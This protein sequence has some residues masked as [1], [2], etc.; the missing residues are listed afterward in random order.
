MKSRIL[1]LTLVASIS[2]ASIAFAAD[3]PLSD[4]KALFAAASFD[5]AL[6]ALDRLDSANAARP[7][8]L[9]YKVLCL[10]ALGRS[11]DAQKITETLVTTVP[12]FA[13]ADTDLS[14]K[15]LELLTETRRRIVPTIA[16]RLFADARDQY[17]SKNNA[18]ATRVFQQVMTLA[19]DRVWRDTAEAEDL[20]T[21]AS[22]FLELLDGAA[23]PAPKAAAE[24]PPPAAPPVVPPSPASIA[25]ALGQ[26]EAPVPIRQTMPRWVAPDRVSAMR[27]FHGTIKVRIGVD[28]RVVDA[29]I[30]TP[31]HPDYDKLLLD[32][33]RTW[34]YKPALRNGQPIEVE[35]VVDFNLQT[36]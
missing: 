2:S 6:A 28:G 1:L 27:T 4:A 36:K 29:M 5:G 26:L 3:E 24:P 11:A 31:T 35:K 12:T 32:V 23:A 13:P 9:E 34:L 14:P 20:R 19:G 8:A 16:R 30:A 18:D 10:L 15:F 7:E 33:A 21:L 17:R 25:A 22:G